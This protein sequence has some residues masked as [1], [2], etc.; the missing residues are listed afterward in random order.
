MEEQ[1]KIDYYVNAFDIVSMLNRNKKGVDEIGNVRYLLPK[2][3]TTTF[4]LEDKN[5]SSHD[6]GQYQLNPDGVPKEANINEHA[7]IFAAGIK[8]SKLIDKYLALIVRNTKVKL[9]LVIY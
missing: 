4:D 1:G 6:F 5:G 9:L 8:V 7:Y 3:F 2:S